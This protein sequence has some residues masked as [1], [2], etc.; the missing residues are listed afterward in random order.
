MRRLI[1]VALIG[2]CALTLTAGC[3]SRID[4]TPGTVVA[5]E[6]K[7]RGHTHILVV[8]HSDGKKVNIRVPGDIY[9]DCQVDERWPGCY[10]SKTHNTVDRVALAAYTVTVAP[11][12]YVDIAVASTWL[13]PA[14]GA[15]NWVD[16]YTRSNMVVG[17]CRTGYK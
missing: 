12:T 11:T 10:L 5:R 16:Y 1:A 8:K 14:Y 15:V 4:H 17:H 7:D 3:P 2:L 13:T 9:D 6:T